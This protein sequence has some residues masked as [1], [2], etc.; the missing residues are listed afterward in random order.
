[1]LFILAQS[2]IFFVHG[3]QILFLGENNDAKFDRNYVNVVS[4]RI[5]NDNYEGFVFEHGCV[6]KKFKM[7]RCFKL[8]IFL[9]MI[10]LTC[11]Y[12]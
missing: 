4:F 12:Y 7:D 10:Q 8:F 1:M 2:Y 3:I 11:C 6:L 9:W 5:D